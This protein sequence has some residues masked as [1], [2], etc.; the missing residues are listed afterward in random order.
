MPVVMIIGPSHA[1][2]T[3]LL[4]ALAS[5][6]EKFGLASSPA[7][8]DLDEEL[9]SGHRSDARGAARLVHSRARQGQGLLLVNVGAGQVVQSD[10]R[11]FLQTEP[12]LFPVAVWC[13]KE[14]FLSRHAVETRD[15]EYGNNYTLEL[16]NLWQS[17]R[18]ADRLVDTSRP[19]TEEQSL[20][21]LVRILQS[22]AIS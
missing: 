2:K 22:T 5:D 15:R 16:R 12:G 10:F 20:A 3:T 4:K 6:F 19:I 1:G 21:E 17:C 7:L 9:G 14:T 18:E 8:L 11:N 13:D